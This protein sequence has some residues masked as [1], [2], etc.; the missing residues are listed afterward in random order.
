M[1]RDLE[2]IKIRALDDLGPLLPKLGRIFFLEI[3]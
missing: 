1:T 3:Q 2:D